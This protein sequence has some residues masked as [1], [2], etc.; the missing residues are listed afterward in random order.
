[1][2]PVFS[3]DGIPNLRAIFESANKQPTGWKNDY[4]RNA[5]GE[6]IFY[7]TVPG[8]GPSRGS[9]VLT[10]GYGDSIF[11]YYDTIR[12]FQT[13]G[14]SIYAMDWA[15]QGFSQRNPAHPDRPSSRPLDI[16]VRDLDLF[17]ETIVRPEADAPLILAS[18]SMGGHIG[19]LYLKR[20]PEV[21]DSAI[22]AAPMLD[23]NTSI[24]PKT[25]FRN[26]AD[27]MRKIGLGDTSLPNWRGALYRIQSGD[28]FSPPQ[29]VAGFDDGDPQFKPYELKLPSWAWVDNAYDTIDRINGKDFF[30]DIP[31]KILFV[32]AGRDELVDNRS[33]ENAA[34]AVPDARLLTLDT[35][36]HGIW[37]SSLDDRQK[38]WRQ[39]D[40]LLG[41]PAPDENIAHGLPPAPRPAN[42]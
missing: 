7:A 38:L 15:S 28:I 9:V 21:F 24:L 10:T 5:D 22:L 1:M 27:F 13:R 31:A 40:A 36:R 32:A 4:F 16:H 8:K 17:V 19:A 25:V 11:N 2:E 35:A 39:I 6:T 18:H 23:L 41:V 3:T 12:E 34:R 14:F 26:L 30:R 29:V 20:H 42:G 37:Q 33:I